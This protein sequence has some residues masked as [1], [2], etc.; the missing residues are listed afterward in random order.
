M[1]CIF[2]YT[3]FETDTTKIRSGSTRRPKRALNDGEN[4]VQELFYAVQLPTTAYTDAHCNQIT[5]MVMIITFTVI[6]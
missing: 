6:D 4:V 3:Q 5:G 2:L 1:P